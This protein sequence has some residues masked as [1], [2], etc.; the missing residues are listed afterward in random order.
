MANNLVDQSLPLKLS[1]ETIHKIT[2]DYLDADTDGN[3]SAERLNI[4]YDALFRLIC[5]RELNFNAVVLLEVTL[6]LASNKW[7]IIENQDKWN[8]I[9]DQLWRS[10][11][12]FQ[13]EAVYRIRAML[14]ALS[15]TTL[16]EGKTIALRKLVEKFL[17]G[18]NLKIDMSDIGELLFNKG[19]YQNLSGYELGAI[20]DPNSIIKS[21]DGEGD[22]VNRVLDIR[23][24][25]VLIRVSALL[26]IFAF[27]V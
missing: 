26:D 16:L 6:Y 17:Y 10:S 21:L 8:R 22:K 24:R 11:I 18:Q 2:A 15:I 4:F 3:P 27:Q 14:A 23:I 19:W 20:V 25:H 7:L 12:D 13:L 9:Q 5:D 1:W